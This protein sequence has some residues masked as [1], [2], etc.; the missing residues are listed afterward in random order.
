MSLEF[1]IG[2]RFQG[3]GLKVKGSGPRVRSSGS[4]GKGLGL[5]VKG[6]GPR[7]KGSKFRVTRLPATIC[8]AVTVQSDGSILCLKVWVWV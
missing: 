7:V 8:T 3:L 4:R 1:W 6:S 5:K 2:F